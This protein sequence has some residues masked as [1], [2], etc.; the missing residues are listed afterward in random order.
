M[1]SLNNYW[2]TPPMD[3][4]NYWMTPTMDSHNYWMAPTMDSHNYW[5]APTIVFWIV[6]IKMDPCDK[7]MS[8]AGQPYPIYLVKAR[9]HVK[10]FS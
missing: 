8:Q 7:R 1:D 10:I 5:M 4:F 9:E 3:S 6:K 2:M